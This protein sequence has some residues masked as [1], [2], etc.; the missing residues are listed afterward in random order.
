MK[1]NA[2]LLILLHLCFTPISAVWASDFMQG[3]GSLMDSASEAGLRLPSINPESTKRPTALSNNDVIAGLKD[4]LRIGSETVVGQL[5]ANN[6]FNADPSIHIPLPNSLQRVKS[7]LSAI[8]MQSIMD[9]LELKL[10]R[11]AEAATPKAKRIFSDSIKSMSFDDAKSIWQGSNDAATQYFKN[12]MSKP[13]SKEMAPLIDAALAQ[14]GAMQTYDLAMGKYQSLPFMPDV[15]N[16]L[17]QHVL[18]LSLAGI[19]HYMA[20]EEAAIRENP[21]KRS[22]AILKKVFR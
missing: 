14:T 9:D 21:L 3:I 20:K 13:L 22:T 19:F 6:G 4:A 5:S 10:N 2:C 17:K 8:G 18:R 12:K 11:A 16:N 15:K 7:A 1:K